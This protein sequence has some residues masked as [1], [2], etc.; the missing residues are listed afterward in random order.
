MSGRLKWKAGARSD[1]TVRLPEREANGK[2]TRQFTTFGHVPECV[3]VASDGAIIFGSWN[4]FLTTLE[5]D[6]KVRWVLDLK[7]RLTSAP[8]V[9]TDG[10]ALI[11][12]FEGTLSKVSVK[13]ELLWQVG[14]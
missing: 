5:P 3:G 13:G 12:S 11:V 2:I 9:T 7:D 8:A 4:G 14:A 10:E 6:G 1:A